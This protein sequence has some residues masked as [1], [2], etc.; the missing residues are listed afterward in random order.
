MDLSQLTPLAT[1]TTA[2]VA[3]W[4][5]VHTAG[6]A[7]RREQTDRQYE[8][9]SDFLK[10]ARAMTELQQHNEDHPQLLGMLKDQHLFV[11][12]TG[13]PAK[14]LNTV[15]L[16]KDA[17][18]ALNVAAPIPDGQADQPYRMDDILEELHR[19][20][21]AGRVSASYVEL[22]KLYAAQEKAE[23]EHGP[24]PGTTAAREAMEA[25]GAGVLTIEAMT[26]PKAVREKAQ[27]AHEERRQ[28]RRKQRQQQEKDYQRGQQELR[29][30]ID[31]LVDETARWMSG[32]RA[33]R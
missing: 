23:R 3:V 18:E 30:L 16:V 29:G 12:L 22:E 25:E 13:V 32:G 2:A 5:S 4:V 15:K 8:A 33:R 17:A 31:A 10:T 24:E 28:Q 11:R 14:V 9:L 27:Q 1:L 19:E 20:N 6:A 21:A 7:W 26:A